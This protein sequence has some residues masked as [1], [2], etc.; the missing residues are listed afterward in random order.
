MYLTSDEYRVIKFVKNSIPKNAIIFSTLRMGNIIP[1]YAPVISYYGHMNQ[2]YHYFQKTKKVQQF[3][4]RGI[5]KKEA[6]KF[7]NNNKINYIIF[8]PEEKRYGQFKLTYLPSLT[9]VYQNDSFTIYQVSA[10]SD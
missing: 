1:A 9:T 5:S 7:L 4:S 8:G 6:L 3:F 10:L 2:T